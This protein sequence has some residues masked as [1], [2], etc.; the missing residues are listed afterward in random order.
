MTPRG[1]RRRARHGLAAA[2]S[3][4][5]WG[6]VR[7][8]AQPRGFTNCRC[9]CGC[10]TPQ[11]SRAPQRP[12]VP[13]TDRGDSAVRRRPSSVTPQTGVR[14]G[15][16]AA[17][18]LRRPSRESLSMSVARPTPSTAPMSA[19]CS[20]ITCPRTQP[21][22]GCER[23]RPGGPSVRLAKTSATSFQ[24][25]QHTSVV[26]AVSSTASATVFARRESGPV[27]S[28]VPRPLRPRL[29]D[30]PGP[31]LAR[32]VA[33]RPAPVVRLRRGGE[34]DRH[35]GDEEAVR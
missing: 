24:A 18:R 13:V 14:R 35:Q 8:S 2:G 5:W 26:G 23:G 31:A 16:L 28:D 10:A 22:E 30:K 12:S 34:L 20:M 11:W 7:P 6:R 21:G 33:L 32:R 4:V 29:E 15:A 17:G 9:G 3:E 27:L 19:S 1:H 25:R